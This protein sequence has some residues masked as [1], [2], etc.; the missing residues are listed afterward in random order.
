M[1]YAFGTVLGITN[2]FTVY[3]FLLALGELNN[4]GAFV[5]PIFNT[6]IVVLSAL[7]GILGT[8]IGI[9]GGIQ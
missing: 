6:G 3:A 5:F 2:Y 7:I 4:N 1:G 9:A 8:V